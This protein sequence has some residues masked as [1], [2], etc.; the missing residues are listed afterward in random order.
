LPRVVAALGGTRRGAAQDRRSYRTS[1][2]ASARAGPAERAGG[3][4]DGSVI[5]YVLLSCAMS[6]DGYIDDTSADR[7]LLSSAEDFDR[8]DAVR[9]GS[10]AILV[11]ASTLRRDNPRLL[12]NSADRRAARVASG[13]P[14]HPLK[15]AVTGSGDLDPALRFWHTGGEKAVYCPDA[16][17]SKVQQGLGALA[18]V[19]GTGPVLD[20]ARMLAELGERGIGRLMVEGGGSVHTQFL[21]A[22]LADELQ[23]AVAPFFVG[24]PGAPRFAGPGTFPNDRHH[25]MTLAEVRA[26]GDVAVL[27]YLPRAPA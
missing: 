27:R 9:A 8:V 14:E 22:G 25:R 21:A 18:S 1:P 20:F 2:G 10:D 24:D 19:T 11:G 3:V 15:V 26:A 17:V 7:L 5:P 12:V 4:K 23:L 16:V 6:V 13:L